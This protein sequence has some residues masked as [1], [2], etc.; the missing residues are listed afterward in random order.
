MGKELIGYLGELGPDEDGGG[1]SAA[2][3]QAHIVDETPHPAYDD[4]MALGLYFEN[5]MA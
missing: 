1:S 3:L 5:G 4:D 2:A